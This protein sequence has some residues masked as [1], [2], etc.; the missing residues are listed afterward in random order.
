MGIVGMQHGDHVIQADDAF[1][2]DV[3]RVD[4]IQHLDIL[5]KTFLHVVVGIPAVGAF[6]KGRPAI[7]AAGQEVVGHHPVDFIPDQEVRHQP[8]HHMHPSG[9]CVAAAV[10]V[11]VPAGS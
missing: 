6:S 8:P 1:H 4:H 5:D 9:W 7:L 2:G 11:P 3:F 10:V